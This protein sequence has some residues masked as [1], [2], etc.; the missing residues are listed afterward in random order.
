MVLR[1]VILCS[2]LLAGP[3]EGNAEDAQPGEITRAPS[4]REDKTELE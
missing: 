1:I 4:R 2:T 3:G